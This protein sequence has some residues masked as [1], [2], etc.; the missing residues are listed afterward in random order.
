[1]RTVEGE[2]GARLVSAG[3]RRRQRA[4]YRA[5]PRTLG[6]FGNAG[7]GAPLAAGRF[8]K[9]CK[10]KTRWPLNH[11]AKKTQ[12][13]DKIKKKLGPNSN[14]RKS[15]ASDKEDTASSE[16]PNKNALD[17]DLVKQDNN[18]KVQLKI[19]QNK[20]LVAK[21]QT[22]DPIYQTNRSSVENVV[23]ITEPQNKLGR[24]DSTHFSLKENMI[25][26]E[27]K[28]K[29][30][31]QDPEKHNNL[32]ESARKLDLGENEAN[33]LKHV[34]LNEECTIKILT[35]KKPADIILLKRKWQTTKNQSNLSNNEDM[36]KSYNEE[37]LVKERIT[38]LKNISLNKECTI[39]IIPKKKIPDIDISKNKSQMPENTTQVNDNLSELSQT[40][41][42]AAETNAMKC[43]EYT[44]NEENT[45]TVNNILS[46]E[47]STI[48]TTPT[49]KPAD[50]ILSKGK[51]L[52]KKNPSGVLKNKDWSKDKHSIPMNSDS[53]ADGLKQD[54]EVNNFSP[55]EECVTKTNEKPCKINI[56]KNKLP[57]KNNLNVVKHKNRPE[58]KFKNKHS[59]CM[60]S[61]NTDDVVNEDSH[62]VNNIQIDEN[63]DLETH[64]K[65]PFHVNVSKNVGQVMKNP[66]PLPKIKDHHKDSEATIKKLETNPLISTRKV[67]PGEKEM[68]LYCS[69]DFDNVKGV[70]PQGWEKC[71]SMIQFDEETKKIWNELQRPYG[72]RSSFLRH[73]VLL[74]KYFRRG[75]LILSQRK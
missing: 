59:I 33:I 47:K 57:V 5:V 14:K 26:E 35:N 38:I 73:L 62:I 10:V 29:H 1:M 24:Y 43:K 58:L 66:S 46:N 20:T 72:N 55:N 52:V 63:C 16:N 19:E 32:E 4:V 60:G 31:I 75:D 70:T 17:T 74:E 2:R 64:K 36:I 23:C 13:D 50:I 67:L 48:E 25:K 54:I 37:S 65:I 30:S 11:V 18:N 51:S 7:A 40:K 27:Q 15:I 69:I 41:D 61:E 6:I 3:C 44:L 49:T 12:V 9:S 56:S 22:N 39:E 71:N 28:V 68:N 53:K 42:H 8:P 21:S 45:T 34:K